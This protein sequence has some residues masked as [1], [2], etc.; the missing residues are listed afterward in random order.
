MH[1]TLLIIINF[2]LFSLI[3]QGQPDFYQ[4]DAIR[5]IK[6]TIKQENWRSALDSLRKN[7]DDFLVAK[8]DIDGEMYDNVGVKYR[9]SKSFKIGKKRNPLQ[10]KLNFINKNQTH[11]G[12][13]SIKLSD[14][15]RDPSMIREVLGYEIARKYMPAPQANYAQVY[16]NEEYYGLFVNVEEINDQFLV[17]HF[18]DSEGSFFKGIANEKGSTPDGCKNNVFSALIYETDAACYLNNYELKS[19]DGWD[20]LIQLTR[21]LERQA[22]RVDRILNI[23]RTLWM[24]AFNNVLVNL[25]S[26]SGRQSQNFYLYQDSTGLFNPI[27]GDLNLAFGS[28]KSAVLGSDLRLKQLQELDPL[29]HVEEPYKPLIR[30]L[31]Q[32]PDR[33]KIYLSH[34]RTILNEN[35]A[36]D[37][38]LDR[39]ETLQRMIQVPFI[40]D[41]HRK[42]T[43]DEFKKSLKSTIGQRSRIPGIK[44]LMNKRAKLLRRNGALRAI[45]PSI[46][47]VSP[48][49]RGQYES[50]AIN[51]FTIQAKVDK[52]PQKV[53]LVYRYHEYDTFKEIEMLDNGKNNDEKAGDGIFSA[54]VSANAAAHLAYYI[55]A[56]NTAAINFEPSN[57]MYN[58]YEVSISELN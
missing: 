21:I 45:P 30:Q 50:A 11:Q 15:L 54:T 26:Y 58:L 18:G 22:N 27:L 36:N 1:R 12:Y 14:A 52:L 43:F 9:A 28:Y 55:K 37:A 46:T 32:D 47:Q 8:A 2:L 33:R 20:D 53:I 41:N 7:G 35:F 42:Y 16:I 4:T 23:D 39:A 29:L 57:Y 49:K 10:L 38:Y 48:L 56:E 25:N 44:E 13:Q 34:V 5:Q 17:K 3:L 51:D 40:N 24:L 19:T 31:L 6:L